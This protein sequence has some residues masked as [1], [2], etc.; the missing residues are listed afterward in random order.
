MIAGMMRYSVPYC[1]P[2][3][4]LGERCRPASST[5]SSMIL[6]YPNGLEVNLTQA[7]YVIKP[8]SYHW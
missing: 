2:L 7:H 1:Q 5:P 3:K 8:A 4:Q 6:T